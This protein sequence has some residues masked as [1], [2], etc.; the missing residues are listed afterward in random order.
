MANTY[1][2]FSF[3][4]CGKATFAFGAAIIAVS[5]SACSVE[6]SNTDHLRQLA[7]TNV[8]HLAQATFTATP[9]PTET[10]DFGHS[11]LPTPQPIAPRTSDATQQATPSPTP[12]SFSVMYAIVDDLTGQYVQG[13]TTCTTTNGVTECHEE[14]QP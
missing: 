4:S 8:P 2:L 12:G 14:V 5:L 1:S 11:P 3:P 10:P 13:V 6:G 9:S 7:S